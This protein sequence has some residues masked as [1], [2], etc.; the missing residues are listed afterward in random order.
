V[1]LTCLLIARPCM[2]V[3]MEFGDFIHDEH[4]EGWFLA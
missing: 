2:D 4:M 3:C 1:D